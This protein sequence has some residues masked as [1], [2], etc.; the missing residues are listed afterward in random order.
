MRIDILPDS[1]FAMVSLGFV[2][3]NPHA[4][5]G[6]RAITKFCPNY[7]KV[8]RSSFKNEVKTD[9]V[10]G[11]RLIQTLGINGCTKTKGYTRAE[12]LVVS[13]SS[14]SLVINLGLDKGGRVQLVLGGN[15][16][17][18]TTS[19][20][21]LCV[22]SCLGTSLDLSVNL[23]V[24][25][26]SENVQVVGS[27]DGSGV[28]WNGVSDGSRVTGDPAIDN[29]VSDFG[30]SEEP[31]VSEDNIT[32][33]GWTLKEI[34]ESASVKEGLAI[35]EVELST[36]GLARG[37]EVGDNLGLQAFGKGI[38]ELNLSVKSVGGSPS[39]GQGDTY[40]FIISL[41]KVDLIVWKKLTGRLVGVLGLNLYRRIGI[42]PA[43]K[44]KWNCMRRCVH[45]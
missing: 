33:E 20:P 43:A 25:G 16:Q 9:F 1:Y 18:N 24:V 32:V 41:R 45:T 2:S 40:G 3:L 8:L 44:L 31:V 28:F 26:C 27:C 4:N 30:T 39:L 17:T 11:S 34:E 10:S 5:N 29:V 22:P 36:L 37:E 38:I 6:W 21:A 35:V 42:S 19:V 14:D 23:V 7:F 13:K 15:L 12:K